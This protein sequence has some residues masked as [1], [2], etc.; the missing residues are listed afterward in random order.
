MPK[1]IKFKTWDLTKETPPALGDA[2]EFRPREEW[3][4]FPADSDVPKVNYTFNRLY[5]DRYPNCSHYIGKLF[6]SDFYFPGLVVY[7]DLH[8]MLS[9]MTVQA[10]FGRFGCFDGDIPSPKEARWESLQTRLPYHLLRNWAAKTKAKE[11]TV[12]SRLIQRS[13]SDFVALQLFRTDSKREAPIGVDII[14]SA[15]TLNTEIKDVSPAGTHGMVGKHLMTRWGKP[16]FSDYID[17]E[18]ADP[19]LLYDP[20]KHVFELY[21]PGN[22]KPKTVSMFP[23]EFP[24][25]GDWYCQH[26]MNSR[27][28]PLVVIFESNWGFD[29]NKL[30]PPFTKGGNSPYCMGEAWRPFFQK[31]DSPVRRTIIYNLETQKIEWE[32]RGVVI[33]AT[34]ID[35]NKLLIDGVTKNGRFGCS[36]VSD[37]NELV[38]IPYD[39]YLY[40]EH[41]LFL[42]LSLLESNGQ[43]LPRSP[44]VLTDAMI[45]TDS[46]SIVDFDSMSL[47]RLSSLDNTTFHP[48]DDDIVVLGSKPYIREG[49]QYRDFFLME[50]KCATHPAHFL[51]KVSVPSKLLGD[52]KGKSFAWVTERGLEIVVGKER[53]YIVRGVMN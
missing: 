1:T 31:T 17:H 32:I 46:I 39:T 18:L 25:V 19:F 42:R 16:L 11:L 48:Q 44:H 21:A 38:F 49:T 27:T 2:V 29:R 9:G 34:L 14:S 23:M 7:A 53:A 3:D 45:G 47:T 24:E 40:R 20:E 8:K 10:P 35:V 43:L 30:L 33:N 15:A 50:G 36:I 13:P 28:Y 52:L 5:I 12:E 26:I 22:D 41:S 37:G 6:V 4:S 51:K